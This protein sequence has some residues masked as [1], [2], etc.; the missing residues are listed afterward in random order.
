M[1]ETANITYIFHY[2]Y[3]IHKYLDI[4]IYDI[5][6]VIFSLKLFLNIYL[7]VCMGSFSG[8]ST[9]ILIYDQYCS[10]YIISVGRKV[11]CIIIYYKTIYITVM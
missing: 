9:D 3:L 10:R 6:A 8:N 5:Y 1:K 4:Y 7:N 11:F 2:I